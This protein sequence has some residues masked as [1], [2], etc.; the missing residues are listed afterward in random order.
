[1]PA[2]CKTC[3]NYDGKL[4]FTNQ[5]EIIKKFA[6]PQEKVLFEKNMSCVKYKKG[7]MIFHE[8][9]PVF[10]I[11]FID[12]GVIELWKEGIHNE[13]QIIHYSLKGDVLGYWGC[14]GKK[15]YTLSATV[16]E[17]AHVSFINRD[18][19]FST[20]ERNTRLHFEL[21]I[22]YTRQL[23]SVETHLRNMA[24]MNVREK[25]AHALLYFLEVFG[26]KDGALNFEVTRSNISGISGVS[27]DRVSKQ[28]KE[29]KEEAIIEMEGKETI[30]HSPKLGKIIRPYILVDT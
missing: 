22:D 30:I 4:S 27:L 25:V 26:M 18:I 11:Y 19:F 7:E 24:E 12:A 10:L 15:E 20:L 14:L 8:H 16:V 17:D 9:Q 23:K 6:T 3:K 29:F 28:L 1:M 5:N 13:Q 21:L 2:T